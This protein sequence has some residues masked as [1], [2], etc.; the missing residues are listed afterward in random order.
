[1]AT[2]TNIY[3][4]GY[5]PTIPKNPM[6]RGVTNNVG[7]FPYALPYHPNNPS[8]SD[9]RIQNEKND[10][11]I[12]W[13]GVDN[14]SDFVN[15]QIDLM[16][17]KNGIYLET[18][19][20]TNQKRVTIHV[21][22]DGMLRPAL[23]EDQDYPPKL[24]ITY[25]NYKNVEDI[26]KF[27][28]VRYYLLTNRVIYYQYKKR[29]ENLHD[30]LGYLPIDDLENDDSLDS[31]YDQPDPIEWYSWKI[32]YRKV[33]CFLVKDENGNLNYDHTKI[34]KVEYIDKEISLPRLAEIISYSLYF[35]GEKDNPGCNMGELEDMMMDYLSDSD[36]I[37]NAMDNIPKKE[38]LD[39]MDSMEQFPL[40]YNPKSMKIKMNIP[41]VY[42]DTDKTKIGDI[43]LKIHNDKCTKE[44]FSGDKTEIYRAENIIPCLVHKIQ[45]VGEFSASQRDIETLIG[46]SGNL[47]GNWYKESN[48]ILK[49]VEDSEFIDVKI[50]NSNIIK[51]YRVN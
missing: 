51:C 1:M 33:E 46:W 8:I 41:L 7:E 22:L 12:I 34:K 4:R 40:L 18:T 44:L 17:I 26:I 2:N 13:N 16:L 38:L 15:N 48:D 43:I 29:R 10:D 47:D 3:N 24:E 9:S 21:P 36:I 42:V 6:Y 37:G 35:N 14:F 19:E 5:Q 50:N 11:R 49:S 25:K 32:R 20:N 27:S 30:I 28:I 39:D 31:D 45:E 23:W